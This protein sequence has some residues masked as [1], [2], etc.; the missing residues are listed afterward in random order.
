[1]AGDVGNC[2]GAHGVLG[3]AV[4]RLAISLLGVLSLARLLRFVVVR[5]TS[6]FRPPLLGAALR[7]T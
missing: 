5:P 3:R 4:V 2:G 1:V 7:V 6:P